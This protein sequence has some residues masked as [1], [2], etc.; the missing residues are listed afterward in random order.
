MVFY[1]YAVIPEEDWIV[2]ITL[3]ANCGK[4]SEL[5]EALFDA[6]KIIEKIMSKTEGD[7]IILFPAGWLNSGKAEANSIYSKTEQ[8]IKCLL[9]KYNNRHVFAVIGIDGF[10]DPKGNNRDQLALAID[11]FGIQA[12]ARKHFPTKDDKEYGLRPAKGPE[13]LEC[14]KQRIFKL[15]SVSYYIAVCYDIYWAHKEKPDVL[16]D[17]SVILN[18]IHVFDK[19][20]SKGF[21]DFGRKGM[22]LESKFWRCPVF[23]SVKFKGFRTIPSS[24]ATGIFWKFDEGVSTRTKGT[25]IDR[26]SINSHD[27]FDCYLQEGRFYIKIFQ[28]I[29][30]NIEKMQISLPKNDFKSPSYDK[31]KQKEPKGRKRFTTVVTEFQKNNSFKELKE[32]RSAYGQFRL[33]FPE[34]KKGNDQ[35]KYVFYEFNDW[36]KEKKRDISE[37]KISVEVLFGKEKFKRIADRVFKEKNLVEEEIKKEINCEMSLKYEDKNNFIGLKLIFPDEVEEKKIATAMTILI[38]ETKATINSLI[39]VMA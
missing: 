19:E 9:E 1:K 3:Q 8:K 23:G 29:P 17:C 27:H 31:K 10:Q 7:G 18:P 39:Q 25:S 24:W 4:E 5:N 16:P 13:K 6:L 33:L 28:N 11:K 20:K 34:W 37:N 12:I 36:F 2:T 26:M 14:G 15:N 38:K 22:G 32:I 30:Q 35:T 21:A